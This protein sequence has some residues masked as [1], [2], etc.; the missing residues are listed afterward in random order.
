MKE[1]D[2]TA[3]ARPLVVGVVRPGGPAEAAGLKVGAVIVAVDGH[4]VLGEHA[5]RYE[6][7]AR[8]AVGRTI[9]LGL[10]GGETVTLTAGKTP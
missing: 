4:D 5:P 10:E 9:E 1:T 3:E 8:V 2:P 6:T 7:L